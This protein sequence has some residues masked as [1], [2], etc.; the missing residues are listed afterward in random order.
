LALAGPSG[1]DA[2][3]RESGVNGSLRR[4]LAVG[5]RP[6]EGSGSIP[7]QPILDSFVADSFG[8]GNRRPNLPLS[9]VRIPMMSAGH[10][11]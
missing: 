7:T 3:G 9:G 10:S 2:T 11:D 6:G 5:V 4:Y 8:S 1:A